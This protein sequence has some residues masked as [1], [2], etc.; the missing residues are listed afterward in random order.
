MALFLIK[1][2]I[3]IF[4]V[5][6]LICFIPFF[7]FVREGEQ[8]DLEM[9]LS[10]GEE[11]NMFGWYFGIAIASLIWTLIPFLKAFVIFCVLKLIAKFIKS[12]LK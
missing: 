10:M 8:R 2:K 3:I 4:L 6:F 11:V 12:R 1:R 7:I 9:A 5:W